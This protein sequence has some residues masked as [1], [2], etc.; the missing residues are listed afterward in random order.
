MLITLIHAKI[1]NNHCSNITVEKYMKNR[2]QQTRLD[3]IKYLNVLHHNRTQKQLWYFFRNIF[4]KMLPTFYF[5]YFGHVWSFPS[6]T[7][8]PTLMFIYMQ[9]IQGV[10]YSRKFRRKHGFPNFTNCRA[11]QFKF[12]KHLE[13]T[14]M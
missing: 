5:G 9:K 4:R 2:Y 3:P 10:T 1:W 12:P 14:K 13:S 8:M 7:V 11:S 6:K